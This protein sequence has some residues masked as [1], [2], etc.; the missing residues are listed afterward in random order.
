M[1]PKQPTSH[2]E[3]VRVLL[4]LITLFFPVAVLAE[5]VSTPGE[6]VDTL[7]FPVGALA[8]ITRMTADLEYNG[9]EF[10][11]KY[12]DTG[13]KQKT[14]YAYFKQLYDLQIQK[15]IFPYLTL[16]AGGRF[17]VRNTKTK[18]DE[19]PT[20]EF[21]EET[22]QPFVELNLMNPLYRASGSYRKTRVEEKQ[23]GFDPT[24]PKFQEFTETTKK[25]TEE[26]VGTFGWRPQDFPALDLFFQRTDFHD[27]PKT[28]D[29]RIDVFNLK[30][31][32][33]YKEY[34]FDYAY[35]RN[36]TKRG[37][38]GSGGLTQVHD[39]G[40]RYAKR[41]FDDRL[42][43]TA[44]TRLNYS[45]LEPDRPGSIDRPASSAGTEFYLL[46]DSTPNNNDPGEFTVVDAVNPLTNV[47]IGRGG[48]LNPVSFGLDFNA[49]TEVD[50]LY[51]LPLLD[52]GDPNIAT[53]DQI[54]NLAGNFVWRVFTSDDQENWT[55]Q[56]VERSDYNALDKRF[57]LSLASTTNAPYIKV[58]TTPLSLT[59]PAQ[60]PL[61]AVAAYISV[62]V[63][64]GEKL[65]D[66]T[67]NYN[68]GLQYTLTD[69]TIVGY[70][71]YY[72]RIKND[73]AGIKR[74]TFTNGVNVRHVFS[75][76]FL[77]TARYQRSDGTNSLNRKDTANETY[78]AS[79]RG[80][81]LDTFNQTLIYSGNS[82]DD[83]RGKSTSDSVYLRNN[84]DL[85][86]DWSL[87]L[88]FGYVWK[89]PALEEKFTSKVI[90]ANTDLS[91]N[92][93][94]HFSSEYWISWNE[95]DGGLSYKDQFGSLQAFWVPLKTLSVYVG[96]SVRDNEADQQGT[97]VSQDYSLTWAPLSDG[98][99]KFSLYYNQGKER[100]GTDES[101]LMP[102]IKWQIMRN[103]VLTMSYSVTKYTTDR[104][105]GQADTLNV[106]LR[107]FY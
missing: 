27:D 1:M 34:S 80:E 72:R 98:T 14:D 44:G 81:Y 35:T 97:Q 68:L 106:R 94:L 92:P 9:T 37:L 66:T 21:D 10:K 12:R 26:Y 36:D 18:V 33:N 23:G 58:V 75:P 67:E 45:T 102:E 47:N 79:L 93:R 8:E 100:Y 78:S 16:R 89:D 104:N 22:S 5:G 62:D 51:I 71:G 42:A 65:E 69:N 105:R 4:V 20:V 54:D 107:I 30:S 48:P 41:L 77:G 29:A 15:E 17:D 32:Y 28:V 31:V 59:A 11:T 49:L 2:I 91:P 74:T 76:I 103:S 70:E 88:D 73:P 55:E 3:T 95:R 63:K 13:V 84:A 43:L 61:S 7:L 90:R 64:P 38:G 101:T 83:A 53:N 57:E 50:T 6:V 56:T 87:N 40:I 82:I 86:L 25:Y 96:A 85:Y 39:G 99:L 52:P 46:D 19:E 24:P 60:I